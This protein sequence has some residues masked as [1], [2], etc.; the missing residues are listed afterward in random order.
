M[1]VTAVAPDTIKLDDPDAPPSLNLFLY[2][3]SLNQGWAEFGLPS[4][5]GNG[6]RAHEPAARAEPPLPAD[7]L[8][9]RRLPGGDPARLRD[10][11]AARAAG[12]R[13]RGDPQA[14]DPSPL[15]A[16]ILPPAFQALTAADL[17][18][19]LEA[20]TITARADGHGGDVAALVGDPGAL[21]ADR[22]VPRLGR[23]DRGAQAVAHAAARAHARAGRPG[24]GQGSRRR[25]RAEPAAAVPDDPARRPAGRAAGRAAR[26]DR[27]ARGPPSRR[28]VGG[29]P[30]RAPAARRAERGHDRREHRPDRH[31]RA[32]AVRARRPSRTGRRRLPGDRL[33]DPAGRDRP[34]RVERR[35]DAARARAAAAADDGD[36]GRDDAARHRHARREAAGPSGAGRAAD[37][38]RRQ[39][40]SPSRTRRRPRR[41]RSSSA[42]SRRARS[43]CG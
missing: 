22:A 31:R 9:Q 40:R 7:R 25:R 35:R 27:A 41:S 28:H 6:T 43:G 37:A 2:R 3:T 30:L 29:R 13:P 20:V 12:A 4:F 18:D 10:A 16:S 23:A 21:P 32:A 5:D 34:A 36:A 1:K 42:T 14:L 8:R 39:R 38:R 17:A 19:Q 33:A 26:R 15:G 11:P 24:D